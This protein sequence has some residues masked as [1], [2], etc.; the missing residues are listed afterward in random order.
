MYFFASFMKLQIIRTIIMPIGNALMMLTDWMLFMLLSEKV[1]AIG[2]TIN[3]IHQSKVMTLRGFS[4]AS[5][6]L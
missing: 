5:S 6:L 3:S 2:S 1:N 4:P